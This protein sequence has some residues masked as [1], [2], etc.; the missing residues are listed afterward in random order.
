VL[1]REQLTDPAA[2]P[3]GRPVFYVDDQGAHFL[4]ASSGP[5]DHNADDV[6]SAGTGTLTVSLAKTSRLSVSASASRTRVEAGEQVTFGATV[7]GAAA[8]EAVQMS[9]T[10]DDGESGVGHRVRHRFERPGTYKVVVGATSDANP[11]GASAVVTVR[12]GEPPDGPDRAGGG[13]D[14]DATAPDSGAA[15]G[16]GGAQEPTAAA[17]AGPA[18]RPAAAKPVRSK[19]VAKPRSERRVKPAPPKRKRV[20]DRVEGVLLDDSEP[21]QPDADDAVRA[22]R[23]GNPDASDAGAID[24]PPGVLYGIGVLGI[25]SLGAW[26]ELRGRPRRMALGG[27]GF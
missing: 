4:R 1:A 26:W 20:G 5:G 22:A 23:T 10:F 18:E 27:P 16:S 15:A 3:E 17:A 2:F 19:R 12:V 25:L 13:T 14:P 24:L 9:W 8:G 21:A 6:L 11:A 7:D